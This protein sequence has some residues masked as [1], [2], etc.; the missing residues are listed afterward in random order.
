[1]I[2]PPF[3]IATNRTQV[4]HVLVATIGMGSAC[5]HCTLRHVEQQCDETP[6][7]LSQL[8]WFNELFADTWEENSFLSAA[9]PV[10]LASYALVRDVWHEHG[11]QTFGDCTTLHHL[12]FL[13]ALWELFRL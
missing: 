2:L 1:M 9:M 11:P 6:M 10:L 5:F 8:N 7:V 4:S 13:H 12:V 3:D